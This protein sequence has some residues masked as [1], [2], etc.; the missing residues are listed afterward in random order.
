V[1]V[2]S[3][4][5][6]VIVR[7][8]LSFVTVVLSLPSL[9]SAQPVKVVDIEPRFDF[10]APQAGLES[11]RDRQDLSGMRRHA[12]RVFEGLTQPVDP[13]TPVWITWHTRIEIFPQGLM[14]Q[15]RRKESKL[16]ETPF[17]TELEPPLQL[18]D[19]RISL[20]G[21]RNVLSGIYFNHS[22]FLHIQHDH[23]WFGEK[24]QLQVPPSIE[25][26]NKWFDDHPAEADV[27]ARQ[28]PPFPRDSIAV[29]VMWKPVHQSGLTEM[30]V[31][32][33]DSYS[34][35]HF[36]SRPE[37]NKRVVHI[38]PSG[39]TFRCPGSA[40]QS[41]LPA[42]PR[43]GVTDINDFYYRPV[44]SEAEAEVASAVAKV[45]VEVNDYIVL[46][47]FHFTTKEI[48]D[49]VW[50]TAW[51][52]DRPREGPYAKDRPLT[53]RAPWNHYLLNV[54]FDAETPKQP[55]GSPR[56]CFNPW[57]EGSFPDGPVS[58]CMACHRLSTFPKTDILPV[59]RG[60]LP[61][62][63]Q[64]FVGRT[65]LDFLWSLAIRTQ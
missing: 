34:S 13:H 37:L 59:N 4:Q 46:V 15:K 5:I 31:W 25:R 7:Q 62:D 60:A 44:C 54:A 22:A 32:D 1:I 38:D 23:T 42:R 51:W 8:L 30:A 3:N 2:C 16:N 21:D 19:K 14:I 58:N 28:I 55:D 26:L 6:E 20:D 10:P 40:V 18:V 52:H 57:L 43:P 48:P 24:V 65:K 64:F 41:A 11:L 12:W 53:L 17:F 33:V 29:K 50:A 36:N 47:G 63:H 39:S 56:I 49:W 45:P 27:A 61:P 9:A 35:S